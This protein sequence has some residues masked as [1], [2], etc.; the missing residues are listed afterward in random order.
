MQKPTSQIL[1]FLLL[2]TIG[3]HSG[4]SAKPDALSNSGTN[5][6]PSDT[7]SDGNLTPI[8]DNTNTSGNSSSGKAVADYFFVGS[9][10]EDSS[11]DLLFWKKFGADPK[12]T[13][14]IPARYIYINGGFVGSGWRSWSNVD[15]GRAIN[16]IHNSFDMGMVPFFV[17]Y[18]IP[19]AGGESNFIDLAHVQD[20]NFV[21]DYFRD[22]KFF[23]DIVRREGNGK[24]VGIILEP[25]FLGY[26]MQQTRHPADQIF[27]GV[28]GAYA[29]G[30]LGPGDPRFPD[31][32]QGLVQAM[33]YAIQK[34]APNAIFGWQMNLWASPGIGYRVPSNGLCR[35]TDTMG[36]AA[37]REAVRFEARQIA[38]YYKNAG[39]LSHGAKSIFLDKYGLDGAAIFCADSARHPKDCIWFWNSD[40]WN[41]Y[42]AF[43]DS[44]HKELQTPVILW[45]IPMGHLN[46][47]D[48]PGAPLPN[49]DRKYEDSGAAFIFGDTFNPTTPERSDYF[50]RVSDYKT[51]R[52]GTAITIHSH[53]SDLVSAG[54]VGV[55]FGAGVGQATRFD[56]DNGW[57][58]SKTNQYY[59]N[60]VVPLR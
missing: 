34:F 31:T 58:I 37:G 24:E 49:T 32:V 1:F 4:S 54:A 43:V 47:S 52:N 33:N 25:D 53:I 11:S 15:G 30:V 48:E 41:N 44:V 6:S 29:S 18:Q 56:T 42:V 35:I 60:G 17:Y 16:Y 10:S 22:F 14:Q 13:R 12:T 45:Q 23:L 59:K 9:M 20:V 27:A 3:C 5:D 39:V 46:N 8:V 57:W 55:L 19:G 50:G 38:L 7:D 51:T 40:H 2:A 28:S 36:V 21:F 26:M